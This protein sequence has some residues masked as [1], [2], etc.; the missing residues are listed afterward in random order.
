M[1][2][3]WIA[4]NGFIRKLNGFDPFSI[5]TWDIFGLCLQLTLLN[6]CLAGTLF[7]FFSSNYRFVDYSLVKNVLDVTKGLQ[8]SQKFR[9]LNKGLY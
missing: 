5:W 8:A 4:A 3:T 2:H 1:F 9:H 7:K 6:D